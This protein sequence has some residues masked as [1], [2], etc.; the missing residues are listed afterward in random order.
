M[1]RGWPWRHVALSTELADAVQEHGTVEVDGLGAVYAYEV[2]GLGHRLLMDD[3]NLPNLLGLPLLA[4]IHREDPLYRRTRDFV[5]SARNPTFVSG[6]V[7]TG[8]GSPHTRRGWVWPIAL[9][10][11]G[12]TC[13]D[14]DEQI[15]LLE[16][17]AATTAGTGHM[18]ESIDADDPRPVQPAVVLLGG[19]DVLPTG[20]DRGRPGRG[21]RAR[22]PRKPISR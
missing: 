15:N 8:L 11:Q 22:F 10:T 2:D 20:H 3:A 16:T 18:H 5:L 14:R 7:L 6:R 12:L 17:L 13:G 19:F 21:R 4:G 9:A 1:G